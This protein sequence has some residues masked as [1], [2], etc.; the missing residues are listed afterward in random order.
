MP[1]PATAP[2][3]HQH[4]S[5][6]KMIAKTLLVSGLLSWIVALAYIV[7]VQKPQPWVIALAVLGWGI[8]FLGKTLLKTQK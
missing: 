6:R 7:A 1:L 8:F 3:N 5:N 4:S 2:H